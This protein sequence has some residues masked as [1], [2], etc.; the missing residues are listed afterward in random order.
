[1]MMEHDEIESLLGAYALDAV[2]P[3]EALEIEA[4]LSTCPRCRAELAAHRE[5]AAL[6]GNSGSEAPHGLWDRIA[7]QLGDEADVPAPGALI[8]SLRRPARRQRF[9]R[10][11]LAAAA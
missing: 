7:S 11:A 2:D 3:D 9:I 5:V 10:P 4:H 6:L 8:A 1:M